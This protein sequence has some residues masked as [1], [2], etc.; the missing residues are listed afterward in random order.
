MCCSFLRQTFPPIFSSVPLQELHVLR[1]K[2][3]K[4]PNKAPTATHSC[5]AQYPGKSECYTGLICKV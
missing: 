1:R 4:M 2:M 5:N 3:P